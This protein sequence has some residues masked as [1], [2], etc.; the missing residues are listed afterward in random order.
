MHRLGVD[1]RS[2]V[3]LQAKGGPGVRCEDG[4]EGVSAR[5]PPNSHTVPTQPLLATT[6]R[7]VV[8]RW[9]CPTQPLVCILRGQRHRHGRSGQHGVFNPNAFH[10]LSFRSP[11]LPHLP[12]TPFHIR[13]FVAEV[14][15]TKESQKYMKGETGFSLEP[16]LRWGDFEY[17]RGARV[18]A[19]D[20]STATRCACCCCKF[21][22]TPEDPNTPTHLTLHP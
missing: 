10:S 2:E 14:A 8:Q 15:P 20:S 13:R 22:A 9:V 17:G 11:A 1:V 19:Y 12:P 18:P 6:S 3:A 16:D 21:T 5:C 7:R 4:L